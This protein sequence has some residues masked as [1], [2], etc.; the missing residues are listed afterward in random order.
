M[1]YRIMTGF[2][3]GVVCMTGLMKWEGNFRFYAHIGLAMAAILA[4][5]VF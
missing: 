1:N 2:L 3:M 4:G 5:L